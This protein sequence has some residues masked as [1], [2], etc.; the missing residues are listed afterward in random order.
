[1]C[2]NK[3][4]NI[5]QEQNRELYI[6]SALLEAQQEADFEQNWLDFN[7]VSSDLR[8]KLLNVYL[9]SQILI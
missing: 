8:E 9:L 3:S 7:I 6:D 5:N 2:S 1:M 4:I